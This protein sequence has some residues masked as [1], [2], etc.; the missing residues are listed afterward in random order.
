[1]VKVTA[2]GTVT[3]AFFSKENTIMASLSSKIFGATVD[4]WGS[5]ERRI[6]VVV[7]GGVVGEKSRRNYLK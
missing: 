3:P 6:A 2:T 1:L 4:G 7:Y 5:A